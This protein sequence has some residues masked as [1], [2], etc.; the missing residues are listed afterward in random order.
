MRSKGI[1]I[2]VGLLLGAAT[3]FAVG[4]LGLQAARRLRATGELAAADAR[5]LR[6]KSL[7]ELVLGVVALA[8]GLRIL[9]H[10]V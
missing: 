2:A 9:V 5:S 10:Y 4:V 8:L 6:A 1:G 7:C 3:C